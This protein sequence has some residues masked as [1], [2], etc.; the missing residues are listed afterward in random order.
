MIDFSK[1][2]KYDQSKKSYLKY[3]WL[4]FPLQRVSFFWYIHF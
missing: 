1:L 4:T 2:L 3:P